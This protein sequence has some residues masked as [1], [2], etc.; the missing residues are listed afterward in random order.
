MT[1]P[2]AASFDRWYRAIAASTR[3]DPFMREWLELPPQVQSNG[4]LTGPGLVEVLG[5]PA[6]P[7]QIDMFAA[8]NGR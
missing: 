5:L 1:T 2:D 6:H 4:Y 8:A 3:W 7:P